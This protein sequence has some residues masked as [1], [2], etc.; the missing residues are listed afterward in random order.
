MVAALTNHKIQRI[1]E[2][3]SILSKGSDL[4]KASFLGTTFGEKDG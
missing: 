3:N 2:E 4:G 1:R